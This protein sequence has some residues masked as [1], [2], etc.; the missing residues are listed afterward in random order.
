MQKLYFMDGPLA[1]TSMTIPDEMR[2]GDDWRVPIRAPISS[3]LPNSDRDFPTIEH[4][5]YRL[6][7]IV[8]KGEYVGVLQD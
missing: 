7:T 1:D 5:T 6:M 8:H 4:L 3:F 2:V